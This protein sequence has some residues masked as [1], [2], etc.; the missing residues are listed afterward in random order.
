MEAP[1]RAIEPLDKRRHQR[2]GFS[3]ES[4]ALERYLK[5][6]ASQDVQKKVA[7]VFVLAE[8]R[9]VIGYYTLSSYTIDAGELTEEV[10]KRLPSYPKLPAILIGRL[11][12]DRNYARQGLGELLLI[13]ALRRSFKNTSEVGA[14]AIV[15]EAENE[16]A[17]AFYVSY[18]FIPFPEH[19]NK[20]FLPMATIKR[21]LLQ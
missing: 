1:E 2:E 20:L 10:A 7:A 16:K 17:R 8:G 13:D 18:G 4:E 19:P 11:A 12:R 3:C 14:A 15:V 9:V 6:Q 5:T 21:L